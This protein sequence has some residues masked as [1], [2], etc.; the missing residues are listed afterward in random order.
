[1]KRILWK[2]FQIFFHLS[3]LFAT[4]FC[5][6]KCYLKYQRDDSSFQIDFKRFH[7]E[8]EDVYPSVSMCFS[9]PFLQ[10]K[11]SAHAGVI[12][13]EDYSNYILGLKGGE[14]LQL[15]NYDDIVLQKHDFYISSILDSRSTNT[16]NINQSLSS[17]NIYAIGLNVRLK[18][19]LNC[20]TFN[21]PFM[22]HD[23]ISGLLVIIKSNIFPNNDRPMDG[24]E[25]PFGLSMYYHF[26]NQ[27]FRSIS[28]RKS[29]WPRV[30]KNLKGNYSTIAYVSSIEVLV[31]RQTE[32]RT[33]SVV[34][35]YDKLVIEEVM[36]L[37]NCIP[38]YWNSTKNLPS[39]TT[40]KDLKNVSEEIWGR[41]FGSIRVNPPCTE[42]KRIDIEYED[43]QTF[44]DLVQEDE[45]L[46]Q[47]YFRDISFK[48]ITEKRDY[49]TTDLFGDIG[50]Y[51]GLF[52]G[53]ALVNVPG[54]FMA[55]VKC[56]NGRIKNTGKPSTSKLEL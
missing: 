24:W 13:A 1:M 4:L 15:L 41:F 43:S 31:R 52:L 7:E 38:P 22:K 46:F 53:Y 18:W 11:L 33:C 32:H 28:T 39:C 56:Y 37:A 47:I 49:E 51:I 17:N 29:N 6:Y 14:N 27:I 30:P 5:T 48:Q 2:I 44:T 12:T 55:L 20:F 25:T 21:I 50:G 45:L 9:M 54:F 16:F 23:A 36:S 34:E 42:I 35:N 3:C 19:F 26:P 8:K 40:P 10:E